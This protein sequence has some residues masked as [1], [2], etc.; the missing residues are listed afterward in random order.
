M[1]LI[2]RPTHAVSSVGKGKQLTIELKRYIVGINKKIL[3]VEFEVHTFP[4][5]TKISSWGTKKYYCGFWL[6]KLNPT[7]QNLMLYF[8]F[9]GEEDVISK[10]IPKKDLWGN[11]KKKR[12]RCTHLVEIKRYDWTR[13]C[14]HLSLE[15]FQSICTK[16]AFIYIFPIRQSTWG[17]RL[18]L[19]LYWQHMNKCIS[20]NDH[21]IKAWSVYEETNKF[22]AGGM[23]TSLLQALLLGLP[24]SLFLF[25]T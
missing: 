3:E 13:S 9:P 20:C 19:F 4:R 16:G 17:T 23:G 6:F 25:F 2:I 22:Q 7:W 10:E 5:G 21:T 14:L 1:A 8:L 18:C 24:K 11:D 15:T 12:W